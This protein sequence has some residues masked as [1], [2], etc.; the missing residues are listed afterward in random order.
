MTHGNLKVD[1]QFK[2]DDDKGATD[3]TVTVDPATSQTSRFAWV[4][5]GC[6][7]KG[8]AFPRSRMWS[9]YTAE[10]TITIS[11]GYSGQSFPAWIQGIDFSDL[12]N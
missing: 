10:D 7:G 9:R 5:N 4:Y 6:N 3:V 8:S 12:N 11:R 2:A 1:H